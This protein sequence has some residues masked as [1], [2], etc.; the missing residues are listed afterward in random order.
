MLEKRNSKLGGPQ[1]CE[2]CPSLSQIL[3]DENPLHIVLT[4][5]KLSV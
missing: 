5:S 3:S 2:E 1:F 4:S